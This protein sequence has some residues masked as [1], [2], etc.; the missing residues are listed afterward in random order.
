MSSRNRIHRSG[1]AIAVMGLVLSTV[2][3]NPAGEIPVAYADEPAAISSAAPQPA[4]PAQPGA[5]P[6][7]TAAAV[8][9]EAATGTVAQAETMGI[10]TTPKGPEGGDLTHLTFTA[11]DTLNASLVTPSDDGVTSGT[12][13]SVEVQTVRG[14]GVEL[15]VGDAVIPFSRI[16][17][18]TVDSKTGETRYTY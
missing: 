1:V 4:A 11:T 5:S 9:A 12:T 10:S 18:R 14:A 13:T 8:A 17:K 3:V 15:K 6:Q 16:G 7:A 2:D